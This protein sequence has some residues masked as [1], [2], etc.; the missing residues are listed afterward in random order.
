MI[1]NSLRQ[2]V[3]WPDEMQARMIMIDEVH[4]L[5]SKKAFCA[6]VGI[7]YR[8]YFLIMEWIRSPVHSKILGYFGWEAVYACAED[9]AEPKEH[10]KAGRPLGSLK[11]EPKSIE[12]QRAYW[13]QKQLESRQ[14][15]RK[16]SMVHYTRRRD[17]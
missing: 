2:E 1:R 8:Y 9:L 15:R 4:R 3:G 10:K 14:R 11:V 12:E 13:R 16:G 17:S 5:G 6:A 7:S